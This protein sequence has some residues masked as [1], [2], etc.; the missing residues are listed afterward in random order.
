MLTIREEQMNAFLLD[1]EQAFVDFIIEHLNEESPEL[2]DRLPLDALRE[3]VSNGIARA[4]KYGLRSP[5]DLTAFVAVMFE[6]APNFDEQPEI[7]QVLQ[8]ESIPIDERFDLIFE[9][10]SDEAWEE[11]DRNYDYEAWFLELRNEGR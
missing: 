1:D 9:K 7:H 4:K 5:E 11:A 8:D 3:M 10:V 6:I 2:I